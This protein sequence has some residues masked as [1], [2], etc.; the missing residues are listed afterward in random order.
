MIWSS[1]HACMLHH[2]PMLLQARTCWGHVLEC[3]SWRCRS[4]SCLP[5]GSWP[6]SS[7]PL[8]RPLTL[9]AAL[10][11]VPEVRDVWLSLQNWRAAFEGFLAIKTPSAG[12]LAVAVPWVAWPAAGQ[13][14]GMQGLDRGRFEEA[15]VKLRAAVEAA[16]A[17]QGELLRQLAAAPMGA[18]CAGCCFANSYT[19]ACH[20]NCC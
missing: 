11:A 17:L 10:M 13:K 9:A 12:D 6:P 18:T 8:F 15:A 7:A 3:L 1:M 19:T 5:L 16:S 2:V 20:Q 4:A 14:L